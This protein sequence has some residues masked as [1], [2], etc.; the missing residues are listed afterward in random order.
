MTHLLTR[1]TTILDQARSQ[2][3]RTVNSA[4]VQAYYA[5]GQAIVEDEQAGSDKAGYGERVIP[6]LAKQLSQ[7]YGKGFSATNLKLFRQFYLR[8]SQIGHAASDQSAG[9][10]IGAIGHALRDQL[11]WTHYRRLMRIGNDDA[12]AFYEHETVNQ[13]WSARELE[14]QIDSLLYERL[15]KSRDVD[16]VKRLATEGQ[17]IERPIDAIKDPYVLEF[18][19]LPEAHQWHERDLEKALLDHLQQFLLELGKG[20]AFIGRQQR[21]TLDGDHFYPDLVFYHAVLKCYVVIDLK[22]GKFSHG[23]LG[24]IQM[25]THYYD[26]EVCTEGDKPTIG[27]VLCT[28]KNDAMVKYVLEEDSQQIFASRYQLALPTIDDLRHHLIDWRHEVEGDD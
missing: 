9:Q 4:M 27:M 10:K 20:F 16:G 24:Q 7:T 26:R 14:R 1:I 12:R 3:V 22:V 8:Y 25:Y 6:D 15:A 21:L 28:D 5:I 23:D 18:L 2:A 13:G 19:D 17:I 11:S